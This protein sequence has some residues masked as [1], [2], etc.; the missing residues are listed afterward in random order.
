LEITTLI[1]PGQNDSEAEL[2]NLTQWV[3]E[4]LGTDVPLHFSAF[5][6]RDEQRPSVC[7]YRQCARRRR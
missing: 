1:I 7:L 5:H 6:P 2:E 3:V 4:H